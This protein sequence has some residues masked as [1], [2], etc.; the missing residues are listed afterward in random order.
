MRGGLTG[1]Q[2]LCVTMNGVVKD[3]RNS[4]QHREVRYGENAR[5]DGI[6]IGESERIPALNRRG[7]NSAREKVLA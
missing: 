3:H 7:L 2:S 6:R 5:F 4:L 1:A